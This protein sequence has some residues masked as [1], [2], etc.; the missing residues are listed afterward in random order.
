[1]GI[2]KGLISQEHFFDS[3]SFDGANLQEANFTGATFKN[4][5]IEERAVLASAVVGSIYEFH[6]LNQFE[7]VIGSG[8]YPGFV[9]WKSGQRIFSDAKMKGCTMVVSSDQRFVVCSLDKNMWIYSVVC[10]AVVSDSVDDFANLVLLQNN[11]IFYTNESKKL[12]KII[13]KETSSDDDETEEK[14]VKA[15]EANVELNI[16][17]SEIQ[18][19]I[20]FGVNN[21]HLA[22]YKDDLGWAILGTYSITGSKVNLQVGKNFNYE[23]VEHVPSSPFFLV[24]NAANIIYGFD[25]RNFSDLGFE[26][27]SKYPADKFVVSP[28]GLFLLIKNKQI[29]HVF[30]IVHLAGNI[31]L[32]FLYSVQEVRSAVSKEM[33]SLDERYI[34]W[35]LVGKVIVTKSTEHVKAQEV[36]LREKTKPVIMAA[37]LVPNDDSYLQ[38]KEAED[39]LADL[40]HTNP[41]KVVKSFESQIIVLEDISS[42]IVRLR[43][44]IDEQ[45]QEKERSKVEEETLNAEIRALGAKF[46]NA[47]FIDANE[48]PND[49]DLRLMKE[50]GGVFET[51]EDLI[52]AYQATTDDKEKETILLSALKYRY[53]KFFETDGLEFDKDLLINESCDSLVHY[54]VVQER[55]DGDYESF[56]KYCIDHLKFPFEVQNKTDQTPLYVACRKGHLRTCQV[57]ID[58]GADVSIAATSGYAPL[59]IASLEGHTEVVKLLLKAG[60]DINVASDDG[61]TALYV[62]AQEGR[63]EVCRVLLENGAEVDKADND[64]FLPMYLAAQHGFAG[65]IRIFIDVGKADVNQT[66]TDSNYP[67]LYIAAQSGHDEIIQ[68]LL[69]AGATINAA[70]KEGSTPLWTAAH[71]GHIT[72]SKVLIEAGGD[73]NRA[74]DDGFTPLYLA[75]ANNGHD[76]ICRMLVEAGAEVDKANNDL[77]TPL[78]VAAENGHKSV[79][80][81][82]LSK[83]ANINVATN[84]SCTPLYISSYVGHTAMVKMFLDPK[85]GANIEK[86]LM[87][88]ILL[89]MEHLAMVTKKSSRF[90]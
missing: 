67:F 65:L 2:L 48:L 77:V 28:K 15:V 35:G 89:Y 61:F 60:A 69:A 30:S 20:D 13:L 59:Y 49:E 9:V 87:K 36:F 71:Q 70:T 8:Y 82:L 43:V 74:D 17:V 12:C 7:I 76:V 78:Y 29:V 44:A 72:A 24:K 86:R 62:A 26:F 46:I 63:E 32:Q 40:E 52:K 54:L 57:L 14:K 18:T 16:E 68:I 50:R 42:E 21:I 37:F 27:L 90:Y 51:E 81:Y 85:H 83:G 22:V 6:V 64:G 31:T 5:L 47:K 38:S 80:E 10:N 88:D 4:S 33:F 3:V 73:V 45:L 58:V 66:S 11:E 39:E 23:L 19:F 41:N 56:L 25:G 75:A 1:L 84:T 34:V 53:K 79:C 55:N